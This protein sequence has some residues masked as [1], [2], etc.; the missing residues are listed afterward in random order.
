M[1]HIKLLFLIFI[2]A[3]SFYSCQEKIES[4]AISNKKI[5]SGAYNVE[6]E[7]KGE[8][9]NVYIFCDDELEHFVKRK[10]GLYS[11]EARFSYY[12]KDEYIYICLPYVD[13][14]IKEKYESHYKI[15]SI[16]T[17]VHEQ[18]IKLKSIP[19]LL[20]LKKPIYN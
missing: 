4:L 12:I 11:F 9:G 16:D 5:I 14:C 13:K 15:I 10:D 18:V 17:I 2:F 1:K 6:S 20:T 7:P 8:T 3:L 19:Y